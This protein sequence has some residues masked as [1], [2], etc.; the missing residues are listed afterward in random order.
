MLNEVLECVKSGPRP[1]GN[2]LRGSLEADSLAFMQ[3]AEK[4]FDPWL[5]GTP[6]G[7][8]A[9]MAKDISVDREIL[10]HLAQFKV[11]LRY[12]E[13]IALGSAAAA[14]NAEARHGARDHIS[15]L[16]FIERCLNHFRSSG[17]ESLGGAPVT[18]PFGTFGLIISATAQAKDFGEALRKCADA[19]QILRPDMIV[20]FRR[21][22][23]RLRLHIRSRRRSTAEIEIGLEFFILALH[24]ALRWLTGEKLRPINAKAAARTG[25]HDI[26][27]LTVL[28]CPIVR[29][30]PGVALAYPADLTKLPLRQVRYENWGAH[31]LPEFLRLLAEASGERDRGVGRHSGS[32]AAQVAVLTTQRIMDEQAVARHMGI[33]A[34]SLRRRLAEEGASFRSIISDARRELVHQLL[35]T[36]KSLGAIAEEVGYSDERSLRR[37][38]VRWFGRSPDCY[39]QSVRRTP[40]R[41]PV[42]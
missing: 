38:C 16:E 30:G 40:D 8:P 21:S 36:D 28:R 10:S 26:S 12:F 18:V 3:T 24:S 39:R 37:A 2:L 1:P 31:E 14:P 7:A 11:P 27:L 13:M 5:A 41:H 9:K 33:S 34:A 29:R 32:L 22:K 19:M 35:M 6:T 4:Q 20:D 17:K 23:N 15:A 42:P 25:G